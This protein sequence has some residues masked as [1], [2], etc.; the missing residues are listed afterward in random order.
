[1][2]KFLSL[3]TVLVLLLSLLLTSC[4]GEAGPKGEKGDAGENG[5][6]AYDL[7][8]ENGFKGTLTEWLSSLVGEKGD[9]GAEVLSV[10]KT[11]TSGHTDTYTIT[12]SNGLKKEFQIT[13]G[14]DGVNG[15]D[16][17]GIT[18]IALKSSSGN[19]DT[20]CITYADGKTLD[21]TITNGEKGEKGDTGATGPQGPQGEKGDTGATGPQGPQ[22]E[23]GDTGATG[24]Q[25]PQGEKGEQGEEGRTVE[26]RVNNGWLQWK[27]TDETSSAWKNLYET[28]GT[29]APEGLISVRFVLNGGSLNGSAE[30]IY[31][32]AGTSIELPTP[33]YKGYSFDGWYLDL[34]DEYAVP[35]TYRVHE[36]V[37]LY[38]KWVPG[39]QVTGTKIYTLNDLAK[40]KNNLGGTYIL[41]NDI[42]CD[43][44]ALP[45]IGTDATNSFRGLFDGQGHTIKNYVASPNQ[46]MGLFGY[47]T[48][49]IRNLNVEAFDFNIKNANTSEAVYVG[50]IA[51][52]NA[53][54]IEQCAVKQGNIYVS[55]TNNRRGGLI[56]GASSGTIRNCYAN[57]TVYIT[58]PSDTYEWGSAGGITAKN[59]GTISNCYVD[60]SV[61]A[62]GYKNMVGNDKYG[63]AALICSSNESGAKVTNCIVLGSVLNGNHRVGDIAGRSDGTIT[64]CYRADTTSIAQNSGTV[65]TYATEQSLSNLSKENFYQI[66]LGWDSNIW[67]FKNLN[68]AN[69]KYPTLIQD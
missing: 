46:Y 32:T 30:T 14:Q 25:G 59:N 41:M 1:M 7:A 6:S 43:G 55:L 28:D 64:D 31:V 53:G 15:K 20:Y 63:E 39:A 54:T 35:N 67:N 56:A 50:G 9:I 51:G 36:S 11:S 29:P 66:T 13:N 44:F 52:Y 27:Y 3:F 2:K 45:V 62:Y 42:D 12:F 19:T 69:G 8:V 60:A 40:I 48:G 16:G 68:I 18:N 23:K 4:A 24:A 37:K 49:T 47:N 10:E 33:A 21:F 17:A 5:K 26:F 61:Y 57:G 34:K 65:Y 58:Q 38:A 22:G